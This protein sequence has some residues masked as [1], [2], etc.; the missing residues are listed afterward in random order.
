MFVFT[1]ISYLLL[2]YSP[3]QPDI[4][5]LELLEPGDYNNVAQVKNKPVHANPM[6]HNL[7]P[8]FWLIANEQTERR[9]SACEAASLMPR[10]VLQQAE[11]FSIVLW[12]V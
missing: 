10:E 6:S 4:I 7:H 9:R 8:S 3:V 1:F 2:S 12:K 5:F 11:K